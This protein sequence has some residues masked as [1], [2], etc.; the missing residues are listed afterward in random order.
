L[1]L[2]ADGEYDQ[3]PEREP[4][5][6]EEEVPK[7]VIRSGKGVYKWEGNEYE[8]DWK[9]DKMH[10]AGNF[11]FM[12]GSV[13]NV[14]RAA[15]CALAVPSFARAVLQ[16]VMLLSSCLL[17]IVDCRVILRRTSSMG[18]GNTFG[19]TGHTI[20]AHGDGLFSFSA[21]PLSCLRQSCLS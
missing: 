14:C 4:A 10:G 6:E 16:R 2:V 19:T 7:V 17:P 9:D 13:Y 18:K 15:P 3:K 11:K 21:C 12:G 1:G 20:W 5:S 8:G